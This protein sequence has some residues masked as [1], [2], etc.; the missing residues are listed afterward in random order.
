MKPSSN[1]SQ[2]CAS[3]SHSAWWSRSVILRIRQQLKRDLHGHG[4]RISAPEPV[5]KTDSTRNRHR[6]P[7]RLA[8]S[9]CEASLG[10]D[11]DLPNFPRSRPRS[12]ERLHASKASPSPER[13]LLL[14]GREFGSEV[15]CRLRLGSSGSGSSIPIQDATRPDF[16]VT[17]SRSTASRSAFILIVAIR[18]SVSTRPSWQSLSN[19][20]SHRRDVRP[21]AGGGVRRIS[22]SAVRAKIGTR[23]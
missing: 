9:T 14:R 23:S 20:M 3:P 22:P 6:A 10:V 16:Q 4:D 12:R 2:E 8:N 13:L 17:A 7:D 18:T 5:D 1:R 21:V 19:R 15:D 11:K